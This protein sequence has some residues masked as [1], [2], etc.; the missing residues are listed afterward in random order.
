[1]TSRRQFLASSVV[2][3]VMSFGRTAPAVLQEAAAATNQE[4][5]LVVVEMAGGNDGLN[6]VIPVQDDAYRKARPTLAIRPVNSAGNTARMPS[7]SI[8]SAVPTRADARRVKRS[9]QPATTTW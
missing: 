7:P 4:R 1:M 8:S 2:T 3:G 6:T 5:I 9:M